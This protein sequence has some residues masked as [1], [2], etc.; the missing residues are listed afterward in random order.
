MGAGATAPLRVGSSPYLPRQSGVSSLQPPVYFVVGVGLY[1]RPA[2]Y[3]YI[4]LKY[5]SR[6]SSWPF[7]YCGTKI[8]DC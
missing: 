2:F 3:P 8:P 5:K 1:P 6:R 7:W 4:A